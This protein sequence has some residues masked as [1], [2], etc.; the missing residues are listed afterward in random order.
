[1]PFESF[2]GPG[3]HVWCFSVKFQDCLVR[4]P[5]FAPCDGQLDAA[6][7]YLMSRI[8]AGAEVTSRITKSRALPS[9]RLDFHQRKSRSATVRGVLQCSWETG[10]L[11]VE[12]VRRPSKFDHRY[13]PMMPDAHPVLHSKD[14]YRM[15][16]S[17][18][19]IKS[20]LGWRNL[21]S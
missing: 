19:L 14:P 15:Q 18:S 13:L 11:R 10:P 20:W 2:G 8:A 9:W 4:V 16:L 3:I 5:S 12:D 21:G 6:N 17:H 7:M 1:M